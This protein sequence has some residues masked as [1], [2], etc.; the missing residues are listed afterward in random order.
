MFKRQLTDTLLQAVASF[1]VTVLTG[2]RQSGKTTLLRHSFPD[3]TYISLESPD[4]RLFVEADPRGFLQGATQG[5]IIDEAQNYPDIFSYIQ[6]YVD[7]K[8]DTVKI[9][10]SGSQNFL[11]A[12]KISQTLAGRAALFELLPLTYAEYMSAPSSKAPS[13]FEFLYHG[14]YPRPYH[15][16]LPTT[17]WYDSYIKTYLERDVRSITQV[18]N[19]SQFQLFLKHCAGQHGQEF[20]AS[21]IAVALGLS[22]TQVMHWLSILEASYLVF[23]LQPFYKSYRK[24]LSKR[25]KL[26]F[27]DTAIVSHLLGIE[28]PEHLSFHASRGAIFEGF[29]IAEIIKTSFAVGKRPALYYW[30][31]HAGLEIDLLVE[32]ADQLVALEAKSGQTITPKQLLGLK[33]IQ[34]TMSDTAVKPLLVYAGDDFKQLGNVQLMPW[35]S[36]V[37]AL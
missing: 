30:R 27:Y 2:P 26:Y 4:Q 20:N 19:L 17:L 9:I 7:I 18:R 6:E 3:F 14:A 15:E 32:Q 16:N 25:S 22:Q 10:L 1:P 8:Q 34:Q 35:R 5:L 21:Q 11:L 13:L 24:R 31:E 29:V 23:R 28:S 12:E 33:K 37:S 36:F